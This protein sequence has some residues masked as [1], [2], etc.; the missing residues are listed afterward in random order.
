MEFEYFKEEIKNIAQAKLEAEEK[1]RKEYM[2]IYM[3]TINGLSNLVEKLKPYIEYATKTFN[4][5]D[6]IKEIENTVTYASYT[7]YIRW[8]KNLDDAHFI[9]KGNTDTIIFKANDIYRKSFNKRILTLI[10]NSFNPIYS[11]YF[12]ENLLKKLEINKIYVGEQH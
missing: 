9:Y 7:A 11:D 3:D 2:E 1:E 6:S 4:L 5:S 12:V 10:K 8:S